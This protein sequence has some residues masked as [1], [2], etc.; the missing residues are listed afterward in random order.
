LEGAT[1]DLV[2]PTDSHKRGG[3]GSKILRGKDLGGC[4]TGFREPDCQEPN[5][6]RRTKA[7]RSIG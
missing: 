1:W 4:P 3:V 6:N 7:K 2:G 5:T